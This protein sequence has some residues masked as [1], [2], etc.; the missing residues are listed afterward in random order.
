MSCPSPW[1]P[2]RVGF[3]LTCSLIVGACSSAPTSPPPVGY[4]PDD[5]SNAVGSGGSAHLGSLGTGGHVSDEYWGDSDYGLSSEGGAPSAGLGQGDLTVLLL[6]DRSSSMAEHWDTGSKWEVALNSFFLGLVGVEDEVTLGALFFPTDGGCAVAPMTGPAQ[7]EYQ[8]GRHFLDSFKAKSSNIFPDGSTPL[9]TAFEQAHVALDRARQAGL[10]LNR[11]FRVVVVTDG[12][13]NCGTDQTR[14][15]QLASA[16]RQWGVEL[17]IIGLPG[18]EDAADFLRQLAA[19]AS[20]DA[21]SGVVTPQSGQDT[22]DE[23][24]EILR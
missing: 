12:V 8:S 17:R 24:S 20:P 14:V 3:A 1:Y 22:E 2:L 15:L 13:P 16:W 7:F 19:A 18:S 6:V 9:G 21:G 23:F 4:T 5:T 11:R 10:M